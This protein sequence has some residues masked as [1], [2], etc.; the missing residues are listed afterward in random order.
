MQIMKIRIVWRT[1]NVDNHLEN[2]VL[3]C[4]DFCASLQYENV[5]H[6]WKFMQLM[7]LYFALG[8]VMYN[9]IFLS[10]IVFSTKLSLLLLEKC[11][12]VS[13]L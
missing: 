13:S 5:R 11:A 12:R 2:H 7:K 8:I 6:V 3:P 4:L 10:Y 9:H 1:L